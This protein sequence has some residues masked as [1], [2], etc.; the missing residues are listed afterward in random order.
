MR[1]DRDMSDSPKYHE[2]SYKLM[3]CDNHEEGAA[4]WAAIMSEPDADTREKMFTHLEKTCWLC[5]SPGAYLDWREGRAV[6]PV[7]LYMHSKESVPNMY[8]WQVQP[9]EVDGIWYE[10]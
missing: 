3:M 7:P 10:P 1:G 8:A 6:P 2:K 4:Y 9:F 5:G